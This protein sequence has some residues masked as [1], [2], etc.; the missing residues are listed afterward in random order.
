MKLHEA[1]KLGDEF[2]KPLEAAI[3]GSQFWLQDNGPYDADYN[4]VWGE[5]VDQTPAAEELGD[6][7][8]DYFKDIGYSTAFL[9][10]S[11]DV[12]IDSNSGFL[13][14][15]NHRAYPNDIVLGGEMGLSSRGRRMMYLNLAIFDEDFDTK[16]ISP[17]VLASEIAS[18]IRHE[19]IH[20]KQYDKRSKSQGIT[21]AQAK[22]AYEDDGSIADSSDR[23]K[24]LSSHIE[25]DAYAHEF[26]EHLL[27]N[28]GKAK[29]LNIIR[30]ANTVD[31]LPIPD[32]MEEYFSGIVAKKAFDNMMGKVY[33]QIIDLSERELFEAV[34]K[35]L[36][37]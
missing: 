35:R 6:V 27:R 15:K 37:N 32:Q 31:K 28:Y 23:G 11:P 12:E 14:G 7:L 25:I 19:V 5:N 13:I 2:Y 3:V 22:K 36:I 26:A 34:I 20:A 17:S 21:R 8:S 1:S 30:Y 29:A 24:Y 18:V 4:T 10:R 16:D 9:V 33:K